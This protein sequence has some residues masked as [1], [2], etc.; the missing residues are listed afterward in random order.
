MVNGW[1][2]HGWPHDRFAQRYRYEY[3][4]AAANITR[5][6]SRRRFSYRGR[7]RPYEH[8][9]KFSLHATPPP[10]PGRLPCKLDIE[11]YLMP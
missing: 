8:A 9:M 3:R 5:C 4:P 1:S 11:V 7:L 6:A 2:F 10:Y